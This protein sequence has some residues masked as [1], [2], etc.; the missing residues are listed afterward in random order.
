MPEIYH[1]KTNNLCNN[2]SEKSTIISYNNSTYG[3][4]S[5]FQG[6]MPGIP[7]GDEYEENEICKHVISPNNTHINECSIIHNDTSIEKP[8][9]ILIYISFDDDSVLMV[10]D[11]EE[12]DP[13]NSISLN[14]SSSFSS[15]LLQDV[16]SLIGF[17]SESFDSC[18]SA[19]FSPSEV[20]P[21]VS[22]SIHI[23]PMST[24]SIPIHKRF[25]H[26]CLYAFCL[27]QDSC[28]SRYSKQTMEGQNE[29]VHSAANDLRSL[30]HPPQ[31]S[32][33]IF[34]DE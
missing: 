3:E 25:G 5:Y 15:M 19:V 2:D 12:V 8:H 22:H 9:D 28:L 20:Q 24:N 32:I 13:N 4:I 16:M 23:H 27:S 1:K 7:E 18:L 21:H 11:L 10:D 17:V 33:C 26:Q 6:Y 29:N 34:T 30:P 31:K 14:S